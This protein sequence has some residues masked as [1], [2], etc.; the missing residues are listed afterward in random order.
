MDGERLSCT[1]LP[2]RSAIRLRPENAAAFIERAGI[3]DER[4]EDLLYGL[5]LIKW[6]DE[7]TAIRSELSAVL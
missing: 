1:T 2:L 6:D 4:I 3:D 7:L 5:T